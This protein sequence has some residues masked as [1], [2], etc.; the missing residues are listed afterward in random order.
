M[1]KEKSFRDK[2][3]K[4]LSEEKH[5]FFSENACKNGTCK[6]HDG[7][8]FPVTFFLND[9]LTEENIYSDFRSEALQYFQDRKIKW[10]RSSQTVL[11]Y[12]KPDHHLCCSQ[13][14]CINTLFQFIEKPV[15]LNELL[16]L[17]GYKSKEVL[18]FYLDE[19]FLHNKPH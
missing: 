18:P 5:K 17:I 19:P 7:K 13:S 6:D 15:E 16:I 12:I 11:P 4:R 9:E 2:E 1:L 10:H 8:Y 14:F 3:K